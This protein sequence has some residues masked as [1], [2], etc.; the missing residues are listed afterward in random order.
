MGEERVRRHVPESDAPVSTRAASAEKPA[1]AAEV[2]RVHHLQAIIG[3]RATRG[4]LDAQAKLSVG[5]VDDPLEREA[6]QTA[7]RVVATLRAPGRDTDDETDATARRAPVVSRVRRRAEVGADGGEVPPSTERAL[8]AARGRGAPMDAPTRHGMEQ[9]FGADFSAVRIHTGPQSADLNERLQA[10]AFT[11]GTDIFFRGR[12]D[13]TSRGGQELLAHELT[14]VVQQRGTTD[15]STSRRRDVIRRKES[16]KTP[17]TLIDAGVDVTSATGASLQIGHAMSIWV[18]IDVGKHPFF[19]P[20][21]RTNSIYGLEL[22]YWELIDV[23]E[24]NKG[25][26]GVKPWND[27][28]AMKPDASTFR[29]DAP[30]CSINWGQAVA[31]AAAGTLRGK[32]RVGFQDV[33]GLIPKAGRD[34]KRTLQFRIVLTDGETRKEIFATQQLEMKNGQMTY[35]A[36]RDS[37]NNRVETYGFGRAV[38]DGEHEKRRLA[39]RDDRRRVGALAVPTVAKVLQTIPTAAQQ[40]VQTFVVEA[41]AGKA[42]P[43]VDL[44]LIEVVKSVVAPTTAQRAHGQAGTATNWPTLAAELAGDVAGGVGAGQFGIP[45]IPGTK[46]YQ[47]SVAGGGVLVAIA[48]GNDV[49]RLYYSDGTT[50]AIT[51]TADSVN[52]LPNRT[53]NL[54]SFAEI[55]SETIRESLGLAAAR[56]PLKAPKTSK[57]VGTEPAHLRA[58][59]QRGT[60]IFVDVNTT[61]GAKIKPDDAIS[62]FVPEVRDTSGEWIKARFKDKDGFVRASKVEGA[63]PAASWAAVERASVNNPSI[64]VIGEHFKAYFAQHGTGQAA[65]SALFTDFPGF[66]TKLDE[67]YGQLVPGQLLAVRLHAETAVFAGT[68]PP[69]NS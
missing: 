38:Y 40:L 14:H 18:D 41:G 58:W 8:N 39:A 15:R 1:P 28:Y 30:G 7:E 64:E 35:A 9:A 23:T 60:Q 67:V 47:R 54:R 34:V 42:A 24:D 37:V 68:S 57:L 63:S 55:P 4:W 43:Y 2:G 29:K 65:Y 10:S 36:Y 50:K 59:S 12:P 19:P 52:F 46:R 13:A 21:A 11:I 56:M 69:C 6:D 20:R 44:E 22:E 33:P 51:T 61:I 62:V 25:G 17:A 49:K 66:R 48:S 5:A 45:N 32:H 53:F 31:D 3:N 16:S 26:I 27:I